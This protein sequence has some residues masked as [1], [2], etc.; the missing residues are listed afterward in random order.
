MTDALF[1]LSSTF[2]KKEL[3]R[4]SQGSEVFKFKFKFKLKLKLEADVVR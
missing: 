4:N 3:I 1:D 2:H